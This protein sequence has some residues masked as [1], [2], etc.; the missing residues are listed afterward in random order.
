MLHLRC[1]AYYRAVDYAALLLALISFP[2]LPLI[3]FGS[4]VESF[5]GAILGYHPLIR[6]LRC[7]RLWLAG[8]MIENVNR[9]VRKVSVF[10]VLCEMR[11]F[12][13]LRVEFVVDIMIM[14]LDYVL[15][16]ESVKGLEVV[17]SLLYMIVLVL[18]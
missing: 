6:C 3:H 1:L 17:F 9:L 13:A 10:I 12:E 16:T 14:A 18:V 7:T 8:L 11:C 15:I 2:H 4:K 5:L